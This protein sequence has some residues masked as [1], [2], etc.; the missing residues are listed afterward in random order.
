ML[1]KRKLPPGLVG[2]LVAPDR[3]FVPTT[4][5]GWLSPIRVAKSGGGY[6]LF[7]CRCGTEVSRLARNVRRSV[8]D[9]A[10]PKCSRGCTGAPAAEARIA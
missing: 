9:G 1:P 5:L 10:T 8:A 7:R 2:N 3:A 6:F 4:E